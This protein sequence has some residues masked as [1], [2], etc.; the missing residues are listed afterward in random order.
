MTPFFSIIIPVYNGLTHGLPRCIDSIYSQPLAAEIYEVLPV[1]DCSTDD[2]RRWLAEQQQC[3]SNFKP[4]YNIQNTRQGGA[5]NHGVREAQ[6]RYIMFIDQDDYFH[7][8]A[9]KQV[10]D[11]IRSEHN[12]D[13]LIVD[14]TYERPGVVGTQLQHNFPHRE[15]MTGDEI[16]VKNSIPWAPWKFVFLRQ[17]MVDNDIWF[18]EGERIEDID[19]VHRMTHYGK[20]VQYQPILLIH[21]IKSNSATTMNAYKNKEIM[22]S[23]IR[24]S[25]RIDDLC[26][27]TFVSSSTETKQSIKRLAI[28]IK[29]IALRN[30]YFCYDSIKNKT[31]A[32][33]ESNIEFDC[34]VSASQRFMFATSY[35]YVF[36]MLSN[37]LIPF[38]RLT[39]YIYR[40]IKY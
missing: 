36:S 10:Y 22:Y 13:I 12:L 32:I 34:N 25:K 18:A 7:P 27:T 15:V 2:T 31:K 1:D 40:K 19:W 6:G 21:Y 5:R 37:V 29:T 26:A 23:S 16:I 3:H 9:I 8:D 30:Y 20:R 14:C 11:H 33:V 39:M 4:I 28:Q 38:S 35:P 17:M 24:V